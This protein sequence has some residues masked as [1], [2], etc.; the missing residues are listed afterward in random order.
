MALTIFDEMKEEGVKPTVITFSALI[1]ACEKGQQ[2]SC[3]PVAP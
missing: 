3:F 2:V 1:S